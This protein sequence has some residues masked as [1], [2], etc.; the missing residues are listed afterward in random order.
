MTER[1][2]NGQDGVRMN[3]TKYRWIGWSKDGHDGVKNRRSKYEQGGVKMVR[4]E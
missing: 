4:M 2:K 1:S 3:K